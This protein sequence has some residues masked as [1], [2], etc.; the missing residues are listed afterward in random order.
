MSAVGAAWGVRTVEELLKAGARAII[1][2]PL[3]LLAL[4]KA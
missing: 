4:L 3:E 1:H 2:Q